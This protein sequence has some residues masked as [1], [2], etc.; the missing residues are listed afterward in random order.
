MLVSFN[1]KDKSAYLSTS[2][3][4]MRLFTRMYSHVYGQGGALNELLAAIWMFT[5]MGSDTTVNAFYKVVRL[6][7]Q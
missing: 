5:D 2:L 3:T 7:T 6:G 1:R 4:H